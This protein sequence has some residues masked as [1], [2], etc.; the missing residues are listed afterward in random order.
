MDEVVLS[1]ENVK[2]V[3]NKLKDKVG[4]ILIA[5]QSLMKERENEEPLVAIV[6]HLNTIP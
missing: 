3:V 2:H 5:L 4:E 6:G 1:Q